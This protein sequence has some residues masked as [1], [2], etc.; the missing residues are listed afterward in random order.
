M[1]FCHLWLGQLIH[2]V[3]FA[4]LSSLATEEGFIFQSLF[5]SHSQSLGHSEYSKSYPTTKN[6]EFSKLA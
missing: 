4:L 1:F 2:K 3:S 6:L 5:Y